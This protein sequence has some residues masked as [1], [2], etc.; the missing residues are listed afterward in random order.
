MRFIENRK[1]GWLIHVVVFGVFWIATFYSCRLVWPLG[2]SMFIATAHILLAGGIYALTRIA[3]IKVERGGNK[4]VW[5]GGT[6]LVVG[7]IIALKPTLNSYGIDQFPNA[8]MDPIESLRTGLV[9]PIVV[10]CIPV[11]MAYLYHGVSTQ[12]KQE[13]ENMALLNHYQETQIQYL[14]AQINPHFLFNTLH[15]IYSLSVIQSPQTPEMVLRLSDLLRYAIYDGAKELVPVAKELEQCQQ[16]IELYQLRSR[17]AS[18]MHLQVEGEAG[19]AQ[20]EPMLFIPLVENAIKHG[21]VGR[22]PDGFAHF[23]MEFLPGGLRFR[24]TNSYSPNPQKDQHGGVGL[25]N[26]QKRLSIR[27]PDKYRLEIV[28]TDSIFTVT[29]EI[30]YDD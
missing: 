3:M 27:H 17:K 2:W 24:A 14:K 11:F 30:E 12:S 1:I 16:L 20:L 28:D 29:L 25:V 7:I 8:P 15:N 19:G 22:N 10:S 21:D 5:L 18:N 13:K 4:F 26:I 9:L 23:N 6:V